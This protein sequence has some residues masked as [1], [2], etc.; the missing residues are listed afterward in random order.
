MI[1]ST[2]NRRVSAAARLRKRGLRDQDRRFLVEGAQAV[3]EAV[4]AGAVESVFHILG[5]TGRVP[6]VVAAA[7]RAGADVL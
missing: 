1:T 6:E 7:R 3:G 5:S 4:D 2:Q